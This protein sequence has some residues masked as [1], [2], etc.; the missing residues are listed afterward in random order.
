[1]S[2]PATLA[3]LTLALAA[4]AARAERPTLAEVEEAVARLRALAG[5]SP[6]SRD[7]RAMAALLAA[8]L[9]Y[10]LEWKCDAGCRERFGTRGVVEVADL[11]AFAA[12]LP[13]SDWE[14]ALA[15]RPVWSEARAAKLPAALRRR[16]AEIGTLARDHRVAT[17]HARLDF[18]PTT[19]VWNVFAATKANGAIR[20]DLV[21]VQRKDDGVGGWGC[22]GAGP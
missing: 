16:R 9:R 11:E 7:P 1:M 8:P 18:G 2:R 21:V 5:V 4:P 20:L 3:L 13:G 15:E 14:L 10:Q 12:C 22:R 19:E 17:A 6:P